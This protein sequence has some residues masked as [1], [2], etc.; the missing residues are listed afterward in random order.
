MKNFSFFEVPE[1]STKQVLKSFNG[2]MVEDRKIVV[3]L[4]DD[5]SSKGGDKR[6]FKNNSDRKSKFSSK[7]KRRR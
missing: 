1:E 4:A 3:E 6:S 7:P 5:S 2:V